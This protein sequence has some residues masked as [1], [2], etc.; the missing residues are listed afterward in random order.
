M[1]EKEIT[2]LRIDCRFCD[3]RGERVLGEGVTR[4]RCP[5]CDG[6]GETELTKKDMDILVRYLALREEGYN[7]GDARFKMAFEMLKLKRGTRIMSDDPHLREA[8]SRISATLNDL[9]ISF[10]PEL[11][12][13]LKKRLEGLTK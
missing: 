8:L 2:P 12:D 9:S 3:T 1:P 6:E 10:V 7:D 11:R 5:N 13:F 4:G